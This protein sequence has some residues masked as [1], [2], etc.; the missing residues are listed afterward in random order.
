MNQFGCELLSL[1]ALLLT[2]CTP[3]P[4]SSSLL[5]DQEYVEILKTLEMRVDLMIQNKADCQQLAHALVV[6]YHETKSRFTD[7]TQRNI[8]SQL[9]QYIKTRPNEEKRIKNLFQRGS[10][11]YSFCAY[12]PSFHTALKTG[13]MR[14][15]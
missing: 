5:T 2:S 10:L 6:H 13:L 7:W 1:L 3:T 9:I 8:S 11:V 4:S 15:Q 12:F 14:Q